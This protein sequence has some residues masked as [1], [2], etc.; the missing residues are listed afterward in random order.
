MKHSVGISQF[1]EAA[2]L[3]STGKLYDIPKIVKVAEETIC[4]RS[5]EIYFLE[6][7]SHW[8]KDGGHVAKWLQ[9][10]DQ[11]DLPNIR[12]ECQYVILRDTINLVDRKG[13][14]TEVE[15]AATQIEGRGINISTLIAITACLARLVLDGKTA[16]H[17]LRKRDAILT[18]LRTV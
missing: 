2:R 7:Y 15:S 16:F 11:F 13:K 14:M 6:K 5:D 17:A 9:L 3:V 8:R 1:H 4:K 10:A 18:A 12:A